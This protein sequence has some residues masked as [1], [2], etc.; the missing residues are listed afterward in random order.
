MMCVQVCTYCVCFME[1]TVYV[2]E[3]TTGTSADCVAV[4][5]PS[6]SDVGGDGWCSTLQPYTL[7]TAH[8]A[9]HTTLYTLHTTHYT[10][11]PYRW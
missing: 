4:A 6:W 9:L 3:R 1:I 5:M 8:Y 10:P 2:L 11:T 7:H